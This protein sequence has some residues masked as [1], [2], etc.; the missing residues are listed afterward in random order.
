MSHTDKVRNISWFG[1]LP[2]VGDFCNHNMP[3]TLRNTLDNWLSQVMQEGFEAH[4]TAWIQ[5]YF[6]TRVHG[7]V[8]DNNTIGV[9][10]PSVDK[11]GRAFPFVLIEQIEPTAQNNI[12]TETRSHWFSVAHTLCS[13]ALDAEWSQEQLAEHTQRLPVLN[14]TTAVLQIAMPKPGH[15]EWFRIET[16][17]Q[18]NWVMQ[19]SGLPNAAEF[20][21]LFGMSSTR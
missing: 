1:K 11:A 19:C 14:D 13:I 15:T 4:G 21:T 3:T 18:S 16:D 8:F 9:I 5:A 10:M 6:E 17:G 20:A 7:F 2:C 12:S